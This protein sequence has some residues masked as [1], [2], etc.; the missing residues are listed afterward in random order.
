MRKR[1][2][3]FYHLRYKRIN[4]SA[5]ESHWNIYYSTRRPYTLLLELNLS[6]LCVLSLKGNEI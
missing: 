2:S 5:L 1:A 3:M 6:Q 4:L